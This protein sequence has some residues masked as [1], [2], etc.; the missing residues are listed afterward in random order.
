M[1]TRFLCDKQINIRNDMKK[2]DNIEHT[3]NIMDIPTILDNS[4]DLS[5]YILTYNAPIIP[6]NLILIQRTIHHYLLRSNQ[7]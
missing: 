5:S 1:I 4:I 3:I 2:L 6:T 7:L